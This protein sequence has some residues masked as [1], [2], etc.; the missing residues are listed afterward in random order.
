MVMAMATGTAMGT[1]RGMGIMRRF[2]E[3]A[4]TT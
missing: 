4:W 1:D 3:K 2:R